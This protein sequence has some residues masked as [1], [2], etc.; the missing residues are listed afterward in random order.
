MGWLGL[1]VLWMLKGMGKFLLNPTIITIISILVLL[2]SVWIQTKNLD[3]M[4]VD[5][6]NWRRT[7]AEGFGYAK[8]WHN[9]FDDSERIRGMERRN[10]ITA[11]NEA[12]LACQAR[13]DAARASAQKIETLVTKEP[14]YDAQHCPVR[15]LLDARSLRDAT[16]WTGDAR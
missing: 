5:R 6:D 8:A 13:V 16:G 2:A 9:S 12:G 4:T 11:T 14:V 3:R 1:K 15:T 7:A 10:A